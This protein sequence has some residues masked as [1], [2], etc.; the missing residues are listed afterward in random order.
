MVAADG[1][2]FY[3]DFIIG[4]TA[5]KSNEGIL[6]ADPKAMYDTASPAPKILSQHPAYG[7]A[8]LV[9]KTGQ[10]DWYCVVWNESRAKAELGPR[11]EW[12]RAKTW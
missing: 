9:C 3:P 1:K 4:V 10:S 8:L 2:H 11:L 7:K 6:L 12:D 5:R